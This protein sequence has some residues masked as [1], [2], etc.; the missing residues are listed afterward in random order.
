VRV[1]M[2]TILIAL[3]SGDT[4]LAEE[5]QH[6]LTKTSSLRSEVRELIRP[7]CGSCHTSTLESANPKAC[8]IFDL[9][10]DN[11]PSTMS[12]RQLGRFQNRLNSLPDSLKREVAEFVKR[13]LT[14]RNSP[15]S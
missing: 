11:W 1:Y 13:E 14:L 10:K 15:G 5:N 8:S 3:F 9:A 2:I 7:K 4:F 6:P 12:V